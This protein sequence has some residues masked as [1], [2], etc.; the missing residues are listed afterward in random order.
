MGF[1]TGDTLTQAD[2]EWTAYTPTV[3]AFTTGNG[4]IE[5]R[6]AKLGDTIIA[7]VLVTLGT[8]SA[9]TGSITITLPFTARRNKLVGTAVSRPTGA[10]TSYQMAVYSVAAATLVAVGTLGT[11]GAIGATSSTSPATWASTGWLLMQVTYEAA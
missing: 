4:T 8:T 7:E 6:Y 1:L 2:F 9:V 5:G 3:T 10:S 11:T